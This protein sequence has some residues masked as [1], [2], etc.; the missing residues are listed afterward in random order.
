MPFKNR[1]AARHIAAKPCEW[2]GW[3][4]GRRHAAHIIDEVEH[5]EWNALSLCPN[6]ATVFDEIIRPKL[7]KALTNYGVKGLPESWKKD[8]KITKAI[9]EAI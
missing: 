7:F 8:N 5:S 3:S 4:A 1:R 6:C 2:C 9:E